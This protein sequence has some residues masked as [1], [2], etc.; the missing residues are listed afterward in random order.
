MS[1]TVKPKV[2]KLKKRKIRIKKIKSC[3]TLY[4]EYDTGQIPKNISIPDYQQLIKCV[5]DKDRK[6]LAEDKGEFGYLYPNLDDPNY[7]VKIANKKEFF[8]TRYEQH[9]AEDYEHI[10]EY[11]QKFCDNTEFE[12]DPH[13]M[14]VRNFLSFQTPY[15]GLLLYH[16]LGTGKTCSAISV[17]E[18]MRTYLQQMG[19]TKRLIIVASPAVQENFKLQLFDERKLRKVNGLW[20]IKACIGNK[21]IKEINPMNMKGLSRGKVIRQIKRLIRQSY[22]FKGYGEF[23]NYIEKIMNKS[24]P[25][26]SSTEVRERIRKKN[27]RKEFSNRMLVI[28]E[29]HNIRLSKEGKVKASSDNLGKLLEATNNLKLLLLSATP[30]FDSYSEI[31]WI[32]NLL[33]LNDKRYPITQREVFTAKGEVICTWRESIYISI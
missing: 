28:D 5:S 29:V 8:D 24:I 22:L 26:G 33:L 31:I 4:S 27:L 23:A 13:Q 2:V 32:L 10:E 1:G 3:D 9:G 18:E 16:G 25:S 30:M 20:N 7:N 19:I 17:C 15:N 12:L 11:T 6:E 21:F 14:F